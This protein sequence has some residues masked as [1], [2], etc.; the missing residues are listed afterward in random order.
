MDVGSL[1]RTKR[2]KESALNARRMRLLLAGAGVAVG[3]AVGGCGDD[4][5]TAEVGACIDAD[6]QVVECDSESAEMELVSD[7]E[8]EDAIACLEI[9]DVPQVTVAVED[10]EFCAEPR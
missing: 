2:M 8:A 6:D 5:A 9:G 4:E 7:L 10:G 3:L 1:R